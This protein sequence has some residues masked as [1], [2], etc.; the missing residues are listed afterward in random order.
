MRLF[1]G[2]DI[3]EIQRIEDIYKK[4]GQ[5]FLKKI[6]TLRE[7]N[8][9]LSNERMAVPRLAARFAAKEAVSKALKIGMNGLGW[10]KGMYF[11]DIEVLKDENGAV[12]SGADSELPCHSSLRNSSLE[13][14]FRP[15]V[16]SGPASWNSPASSDLTRYL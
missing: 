14:L 15:S 3:C 5:E 6:Y 8:Y 7:I 9:C 2:T 10:E 11:K 13:A 1:L 12:S 4:Y 16:L